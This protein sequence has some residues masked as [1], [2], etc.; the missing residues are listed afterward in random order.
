MNED[1]ATEEVRAARHRM[2]AEYGHTTRALIAHHRRYEKKL[3]GRI[4][5]DGRMAVREKATA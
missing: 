2:S 1:E 5:K 4:L 3:D